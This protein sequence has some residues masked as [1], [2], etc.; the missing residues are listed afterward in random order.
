[1]ASD[2]LVD[3]MVVKREIMRFAKRLGM[4]Y[5]PDFDEN[6]SMS[7]NVE[8]AKFNLELNQDRTLLS[9][10]YAVSPEY[11]EVE[12]LLVRALKRVKYSGGFVYNATYAEPY[13][14]FQ[15]RLSNAVISAEN[16]EKILFDCIKLWGEVRHGNKN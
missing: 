7:F 5:I 11:S 4:N 2:Q 16:I 6:Q 8:G 10:S 14:A 13:I 1:M 9:V 15:T 3:V 12:D